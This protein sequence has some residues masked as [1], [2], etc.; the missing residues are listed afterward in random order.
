MPLRLNT[1]TRYDL[2]I[3]TLPNKSVGQWL[4]L[5]CAHVDLTAVNCG[6]VF[7]GA[8]QFELPSVVD[9][10][11]TLLV[12]W[13]VCDD[14]LPLLCCGHPVDIIWTVWDTTGRRRSMSTLVGLV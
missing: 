2:P 1:L 11:E 7:W 4:P 9:Q 12:T 3:I 13:V 8:H 10:E 6:G 5:T 14:K